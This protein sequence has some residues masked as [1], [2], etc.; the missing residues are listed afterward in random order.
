MIKHCL[1][2]VIVLLAAVVLTGCPGS[3]SADQSALTGKWV[4]SKGNETQT[5]EF[6]PPN[7]FKYHKQVPIGQSFVGPADISGE[8]KLVDDTHL[9]LDTF[10]GH[11]ELVSYSLAS[12][13]LTIPIPPNTETV[14]SRGEH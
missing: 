9:R 10:G 13:T 6:L 8:Y 12:A 14:Y 1:I 4:T 11:P 3:P 2:S 7:L 5:L